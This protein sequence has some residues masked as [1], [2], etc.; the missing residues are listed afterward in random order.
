MEHDPDVRT[1]DQLDLLYGREGE[2]LPLAVRGRGDG[3]DLAGD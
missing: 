3:L 1:F 2:R